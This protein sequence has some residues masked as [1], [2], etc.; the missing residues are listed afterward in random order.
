M[1][2]DIQPKKKI[3][4]GQNERL[5]SVVSGA[6][7]LLWA[8]RRPS[9][10]LLPLSLSGGYMLYRGLTGTCTFYEVLDIDRAGQNGKAGIKVDRAM[11]I[12]RPRAEV[13]AFWRDFENLPRFMQHLESVR[14]TG[15]RQSHWVAKA[16][17]DMQVEWDAEIFEERENELISW[18][19]LPG[20]Q[21]D[22]SGIVRFKDAPGDRGTEVQV[23]LKYNPPGGSASAAFAKLFGEEPD[24]QVREDL[25]R[26]KQILETGETATITGQASGRV[27]EIEEEREQ[28]RRHKKIDVVQ[29]ASEASFPASDPPAWT[30]R[31]A[32]G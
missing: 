3:N 21:I 32:E 8:L 13:Y 5:I 9:R 25:R 17:L 11:T 26:F 18:R 14:V 23:S 20:S 19:S 4:V 7:L 29:E 30:D 27:D 28:I 16:P 31:G 1:D 24:R 12:N 15:E 2:M 10:L 22:N 6:A